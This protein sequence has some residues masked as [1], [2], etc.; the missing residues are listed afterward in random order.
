IAIGLS[1]GFIEPLE[2][3]AIQT[4]TIAA[5]QLVKNFPGKPIPQ[6]LADR[7]NRRMEACYEMV[8]DFI[9]SH[10]YA[11]NRTEPFWQAARS[12]CV[13]SDSLKQNLELWPIEVTLGGQ[14][15]AEALGAASG[16]P[17]RQLGDVWPAHRAPA[18]RRTQYAAGTPASGTAPGRDRGG[19]TAGGPA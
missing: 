9:V 13:L 1:G 3:T 14:T 8:R 5:N 2:A 19:E 6:A 12:P 18:S 15:D 7:F 4:I 16:A 10:Y 11:S 17:S